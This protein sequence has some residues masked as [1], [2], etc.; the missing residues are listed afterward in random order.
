MPSRIFAPFAL[1]VVA[2]TGCSSTPAQ[3]AEPSEVKGTLLLP[4]GQP[5][6]DVTILFLATSGE[7]QPGSYPIKDDGKFTVRLNGGKYTYA[8]EGKNALPKYTS[9]LPEHSV[10]IPSG[11][12][13]NLT[14]KLQN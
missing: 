13:Q 4:N 14:I 11:G 9:N 5:A 8:L 12:T 2:L 7:Q 3:R 6:K 1:V 10:E